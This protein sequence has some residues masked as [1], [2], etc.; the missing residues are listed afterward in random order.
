[1]QSAAVRARMLQSAAVRALAVPRGVH[2]SLFVGLFV[3]AVLRHDEH[4]AIAALAPEQPFCYRARV[5]P[6]LS[7][8]FTLRGGGDSRMEPNDKDIPADASAPDKQE[9]GEPSDIY[10]CMRVCV[11]VCAMEL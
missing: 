7:R 3:S 10:V 8:F 9:E 5:A 11:R 2:K 6:T 1:M 4:F